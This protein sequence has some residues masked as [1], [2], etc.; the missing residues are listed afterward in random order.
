MK[1][2]LLTISL[3]FFIMGFSQ[4]FNIKELIKL[5]SFNIDNFESY[6]TKKGYSSKKS[7]TANKEILYTYG[8]YSIIRSEK[9]KFKK[10]GLS[11]QFESEKMCLAAKSSLKKTDYKIRVEQIGD[12]GHSFFEYYKN[13][14]NILLNTGTRKGKM[15]Y[16]ISIE[17][18]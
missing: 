2:L 9:S 3:F 12:H 16:A 5:R 15:F 11:Y 14:I 8:S 10:V 1:Y 18:F 13:D 6:V 4:K 17:S 7:D